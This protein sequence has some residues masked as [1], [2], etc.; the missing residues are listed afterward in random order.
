M[1]TNT[2]ATRRPRSR[3]AAFFIALLGAVLFASFVSLGTW[4][5]E[6]RAWKHELIVR[7]DQRVHAPAVAA[8]GPAAWPQVN[9]TDDEYRHVALTG[10]FQ[11]DKETLVQAVTTHGSGFWVITPL[12]LQDGSTV[13]V[14]RG[15]VPAE[16]ADRATRHGG[17]PAGEVAV[18]GLLRITEP[19]GAFLRDNDVAGN[20]WYSRD[21][22]AIAAARGLSGPVAPYFVDAEA[23]A[24]TA[25]SEPVGGLTVIAYKDNHLVYALTW[26]ALA[27]M[28]IAGAWQFVRAERWPRQGEE[29]TEGRAD[30][31]AD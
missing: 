9:A 31:T 28:V 26:Y 30:A 6:R 19:G 2:V 4:Q 17:E 12:R 5:V 25:T 7:V 13:L 11:H 20:R 15:F 18:A 8:P 24:G 1:A 10:Q 22:A 16:N 27:L 14:N 23:M 21:V 29:A 3:V